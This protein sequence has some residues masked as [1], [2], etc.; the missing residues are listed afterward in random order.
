MSADKNIFPWLI[1]GGSAVFPESDAAA[2][3]SF[4]GGFY[5]KF[6]A[7]GGP[8]TS[9]DTRLTGL[10]VI[11]GGFPEEHFFG[12]GIPAGAGAFPDMDVLQ[13]TGAR[14]TVISGGVET[15]VIPAGALWTSLTPDGGPLA[16]FETADGRRVFISA[17]ARPVTGDT[18]KI[19][20]R[21]YDSS[22]PAK[23]ASMS[24]FLRE[25]LGPA[26]L[27][28]EHYGSTAVPGLPAK[29]VID[30]IVETPSFEAARRAALPVLSGRDWEYWVYD[31]H[32]I[33][34]RRDTESRVR[35]HHIHIATP[36]HR[37]WEGLAFRDYL[38]AHPETAAAY[39]SLKTRLAES[40]GTDREGYT[41]AK[42]EF[43]RKTTLAALDKTA[44]S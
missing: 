16:E 19:E 10:T 11:G 8:F 42:T 3:M 18:D 33:F 38:R 4:I 22:W 26:A 34:I 21:P 2:K 5:K 44:R 31:G 23:F 14:I 43:V 9:P 24:A 35:T 13:I 25:K 36:G 41:A 12:A 32:M 1:A 15:R 20:I 37:L 39:A 28:I 7:A 29:P 27:R 30:I 6:E 17:L 40:F